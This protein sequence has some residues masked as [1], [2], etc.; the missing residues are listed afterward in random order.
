MFITG[1][2]LSKEMQD[3]DLDY[4]PKVIVVDVKIPGDTVKEQSS[5]KKQKNLT[6]LRHPLPANETS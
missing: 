4:Y 5:F 1:L 6:T 2:E 3:I